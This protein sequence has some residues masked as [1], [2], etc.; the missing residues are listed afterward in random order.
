MDYTSE[1]MTKKEAKRL[2]K[3]I[4][5]GFKY[6]CPAWHKVGKGQWIVTVHWLPK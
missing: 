5:L 3:L 2:A 4:W 1:I 6:A